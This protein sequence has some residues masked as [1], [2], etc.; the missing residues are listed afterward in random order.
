MK[1]TMTLIFI[2]LLSALAGFSG[3]ITF[4]I[5]NEMFQLDNFDINA[6][7][8]IFSLFKISQPNEAER[9]TRDL[10]DDDGFLSLIIATQAFIKQQSL[11]SGHKDIDLRLFSE[12][13]LLY[14]KNKAE[15][16]ERQAQQKDV[17]ILKKALNLCLEE[18]P[19]NDGLCHAHLNTI[20]K[21]QQTPNLYTA[22]GKDIDELIFQ[23]GNLG[24]GPWFSQ[25]R[26]LLFEPYIGLFQY[27]LRKFVKQIMP[28]HIIGGLG[29]ESHDHPPQIPTITVPVTESL[30]L[31]RFTFDLGND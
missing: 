31:S 8:E 7:Q 6:N 23:S 2:M 18:W 1:Q 30:A 21:L 25:I 29:P 13:A 15:D 9:G 17:E 16:Y 28:G 24:D 20:K 3:S 12:Q 27:D 26:A 5:D 14:L 19:I 22:L 10:I 11:S 4:H